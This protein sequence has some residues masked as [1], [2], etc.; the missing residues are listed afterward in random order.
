MGKD[1]KGVAHTE[2]KMPESKTAAKQ[3]RMQR[4]TGM[5]MM[6]MIEFDTPWRILN[7]GEVKTVKR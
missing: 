6:I 2:Q 4:S 1:S 3:K 7:I 5:M